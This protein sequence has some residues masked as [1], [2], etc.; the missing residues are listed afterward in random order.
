MCATGQQEVRTRACMVVLIL[1][2]LALLQPT[3]SRCRFYVVLSTPVLEQ[4]R[5]IVF[6]TACVAQAWCWS[7]PGFRAALRKHQSLIQC[8]SFISSYRLHLKSV[9]TERRSAITPVLC[10]NSCCC[11]R[12]AGSMGWLGHGYK[13]RVSFD[14]RDVQHKVLKVLHP[15]KQH[16]RHLMQGRQGQIDG[17]DYAG[18]QGASKF[19]Y[20]FLAGVPPCM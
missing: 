18:A 8:R 5:G 17:E 7:S 15:S 10:I 16:T 2:V 14:G 1:S 19:M 13:G 9:L 6:A 4:T 20:R 11:T 3:S 12:L